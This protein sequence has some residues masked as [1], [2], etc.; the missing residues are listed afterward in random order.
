MLK[1]SDSVKRLCKSFFLSANGLQ[2][3][4]TEAHFM[5][6]QELYT[7]RRYNQ[8]FSKTTLQVV[9]YRHFASR[10]FLSANGLQNRFTEAH[11]MPMGSITLEIR[12]LLI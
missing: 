9:F 10:F 6:K 12:T 11:F 4:F 5:L 7:S 8:R 3:R 2:N 1:I